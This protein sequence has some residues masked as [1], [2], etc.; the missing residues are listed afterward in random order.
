MTDVAELG[1]QVQALRDEV[2]ALRATIERMEADI[3]ALFNKWTL[4]PGMK[5]EIER[6]GRR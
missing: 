3:Q 4:P 6:L 1:R 5:E 2:A